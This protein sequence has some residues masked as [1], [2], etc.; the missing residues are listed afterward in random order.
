M[1]ESIED[2]TVSVGGDG[3]VV[4]DGEVCSAP[5]VQRGAGELEAG[6]GNAQLVADLVEEAAWLRALA[7]VATPS[8]LWVEMA[9]DREVGHVT[10]V[11]GRVLRHRRHRR[12]Y[13][14]SFVL[15]GNDIEAPVWCRSDE[16]RHRSVE[17]LSIALKH[18]LDSAAGIDTD[19]VIG[20]RLPILRSGGFPGPSILKLRAQ[21]LFN[22]PGR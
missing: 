2:I 20:R 12:L 15:S 3:M 17:A 7:A 4:D 9:L 8:A 6:G 14:W 22:A 11:E 5:V 18:D 13:V 1:E 19:M 21:V 16:L 10:E